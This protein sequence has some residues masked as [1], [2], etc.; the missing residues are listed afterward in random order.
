MARKCGR[1]PVLDEIKQRE[2]VAI[3]SMGCSRRT[4]ARYVGCDPKTIQNTAEREDKFAEKLERAQSQAVVTHVKN[5]NS[6]A[7]KAQY[8]RAAA[9]A[10]ERLNPEE[11]AAPHTD[12]LSAEQI[13]KLLAY[14]SQVVVEEVP[15][16]AYRKKIMKRLGEMTKM[17]SAVAPEKRAGIVA[18]STQ[19]NDPPKKR[20]P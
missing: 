13:F 16:S 3:V 11:Y 14:L 18:D 15:V 6:A 5:I 7:K 2:I 9:W 8:W 10:L 19:E 4:A 1:P 20:L 12:M 17:I